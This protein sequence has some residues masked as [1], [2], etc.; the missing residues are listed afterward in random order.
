MNNERPKP[1][2]LKNVWNQPDTGPF[3]NRPIGNER[4][5]RQSDC[6]G[7]I[8]PDGHLAVSLVGS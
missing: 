1:F 8:K 5:A 7:D 2:R 4:A 3:L 6:P